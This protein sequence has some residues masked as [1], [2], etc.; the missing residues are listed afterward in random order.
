M[1]ELGYLKSKADTDATE[2]EIEKLLAT[3]YIDD[4]MLKTDG[5]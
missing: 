2:K 5:Y 3:D 1:A 4:E